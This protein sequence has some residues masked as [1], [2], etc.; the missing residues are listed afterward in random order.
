ML[1]LC[2]WCIWMT[3]FLALHDVRGLR[4]RIKYL[5]DCPSYPDKHNSASWNTKRSVSF[6][7]LQGTWFLHSHLWPGTC[8]GYVMVIQWDKQCGY[9]CLRPPTHVT[10]WPEM[11]RIDTQP[12]YREQRFLIRRPKILIFGFHQNRVLQAF[13][14]LK[15]LLLMVKCDVLWQFQA[16]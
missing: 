9:M 14:C 3:P 12:H 5:Q 16:F 8:G 4:V 6:Y 2:H 7:F 1:V 11:S 15:T 13:F 10:L